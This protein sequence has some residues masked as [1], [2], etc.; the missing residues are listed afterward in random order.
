MF[1]SVFLDVDI[2]VIPKGD[3]TLRST[4]RKVGQTWKWCPLPVLTFCWRELCPRPPL[5]LGGTGNCRREHVYW[6]TTGS[7]RH[8]SICPSTE[9]LR[10]SQACN[11]K[12]NHHRPLTMLVNETYTKTTKPKFFPKTWRR[13]N[14]NELVSSRK[15]QRS[16][17]E[18]CQMSTQKMFL[19]FRWMGNWRIWT[20][21]LLGMKL[22]WLVFLNTHTHR[23][24]HTDT[25]TPEVR[26]NSSSDYKSRSWDFPVV[27]WLRIRLAVQG[28]LLRSPVRKLRSHMRWSQQALV[29]HSYWACAL[30]RP[31]VESQCIQQ[32]TSHD[33]VEI[34][35]VKAKT[36]G[37]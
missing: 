12:S 18:M 21:F 36:S 34:S 8:K 16:A 14:R 32:K 19:R 15:K 2:P 33:A 20:Q 22:L 5:L 24:T 4:S 13:T 25:R 1:P 28:T 29:L 23:H 37:S 27:Q 9:N 17:T 3:R 31:Q 7:L 30:W 26:V 6:W 10:C 35:L 11:N